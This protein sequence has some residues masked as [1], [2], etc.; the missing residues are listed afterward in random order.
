MRMWFVF[1]VQ[2]FDKWN[3]LP[4]DRRSAPLPE[5][6]GWC[7]CNCCGKSIPVKDK[8][9]RLLTLA[10]VD[11]ASPSNRRGDGQGNE[12]ALQLYNRLPDL[13]E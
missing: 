1:H 11:V 10:Q 8:A 2:V 12:R 6:S 3:D 7:D 4:E 13:D 9:Q 5:P